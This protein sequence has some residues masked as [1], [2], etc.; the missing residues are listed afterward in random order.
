VVGLGAA[1]AVVLDLRLANGAL[2]LPITAVQL[3]WINL[4]SDGAPALALGFDRNPGVMQLPP[5]PPASPL[6]DRPSVQFIL[7]TGG[8]KAMVAAALLVL[9]PVWGFS[10]DVTQTTTFLFLGAGQLLFAYPARRTESESPPNHVLHVAVLVGAL[11]QV[12][13]IVVEPLRQALGAVPLPP[14][15]WL[16]ASVAV[17]ASWSLAELTSR[18]VWWTQRNQATRNDR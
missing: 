13:V 3:L 8:A 17:L 14:A 11:L 1:A 15:L 16:I 7:V 5:R 12:L 18:L 10:L 9:L 2:L 6:L 4:M